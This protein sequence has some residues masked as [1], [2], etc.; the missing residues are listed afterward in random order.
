M[1]NCAH[2]LAGAIVDMKVCVL[3]SKVSVTTCVVETLQ[4]ARRST[5]HW[6]ETTEHAGD[7]IAF[8]KRA[9]N[10]ASRQVVASDE[11]GPPAELGRGQR[12]GCASLR[13][14]TAEQGNRNLAHGRSAVRRAK[15]LG[16]P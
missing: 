16:S 3:R 8:G 12:V 15:P 2:A 6:C 9:E 4:L 5:I 1:G 13:R 11:G 14:Q 7:L 10:D